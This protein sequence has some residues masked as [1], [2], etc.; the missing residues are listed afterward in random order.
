MIKTFVSRIALIL[1]LIMLFSACGIAPASSDEQEKLVTDRPQPVRE[2]D[3]PASTPAPASPGK[4][5][6]PRQVEL[7]SLEEADNVSYILIYNPGIYYQELEDFNDTL[8]T[9]KL[10]TQIDTSMRRGEGLENEEQL[11]GTMPQQPIDVSIIEEFD[12]SGSRAD[13]F[14]APYTVGDT[15]DFYCTDKNG[16]IAEK[17]TFKCL[18]VGDN[19][20]VWTFK[21][22]SGVSRSD[23]ENVGK[24][25]DDKIYE[26][27]VA[28]FGEPRFAENGHKV[29]ILLYNTFSYGVAGFFRPYDLFAST[30]LT[31]AQIKAYCMNTDHAILHVNSDWLTEDRDRV[32]STVAHEFQ[33]L[34]NFSAFFENNYHNGNTWLNEA[35]SGW[36]ED[37]IYPGCQDPGRYNDMADSDRLR[38]GQSLYNFTVDS[39]RFL[40]DIGVYGSVFLFSSY[41][42]NLAGREVFHG[43]HDYWRSTFLDPT[44]AA[45]IRSAVSPETEKMID[46]VIDYPAPFTEGMTEDEIWLSKLA[47]SFYLA[48]LRYDSDDPAQFAALDAM[49]LLYDQINASDIEGGGRVI[50]AIKGGR[51]TIPADADQGLVYIGLDKEFNVVTAPLFR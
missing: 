18:Y 31:E 17:K 20:N 6:S 46:G 13:D 39:S 29:N 2:T 5:A 19:V 36:I 42:E 14:F 34:I 45:A 12:L 10:G 27:C 44:D 43:I 41:L 24:E 38:Y 7:P 26:N 4:T 23:A 15:H 40:F 28:L 21:N 37:Y 50:A 49:T 30:E 3:P 16:R 47:L 48:Q 32:F 25:F 1:A 11:I 35:M 8:S 33:H 51:F 9:G 22:S